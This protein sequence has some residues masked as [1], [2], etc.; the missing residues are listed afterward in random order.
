[1][2]HHIGEIITG[3]REEIH[4]TQSQLS[5]KLCSVTELTRIESNQRVPNQ[6]LL[7]ML[8][9]RLGKATDRLEYILP[10]AVYQLYELR[11]RIQREI[12]YRRLEAAE[13]L[14]EEYEKKKAAYQPLHTQFIE[15]ERAQIA[16]IRKKEAGSVLAHLQKAIAQTMEEE[17]VLNRET[18]LSADE[19]RLLLFRWEVC[20]GTEEER[21]VRELGRILEYMEQRIFETEELVRVYPYAVILCERQGIFTKKEIREAAEKALE[22]L[23][24]S[25]QILFLVEILEILIRYSESEQEEKEYQEFRRSVVEVQKEYGVHYEEFPL[26]RCFNR[27]FELD[28]DVIRRT[29]SALHLSQEALCEDICTQETLSRIERGKNVP[30]NETLNKLMKKMDRNRQRIEMNIVTERYEAIQIE[31][32]LAKLESRKESSKYKEVFAKLKV[33]IDM[34][35]LENQQYYE[36]MVLVIDKQKYSY[37]EMIQKLYDI[38]RITL[39]VPLNEIY[40]YPLTYQEVLI[41]NLIAVYYCWEGKIDKGIE[42]WYKILENLK[43]TKIDK[44]FLSREWELILG[45]IA[46]RIAESGEEWR[47]IELSKERLQMQL[48]MGKGVHIGRTIEIITI[49]MDRSKDEQYIEYFRRAMY[50]FKLM[51]HTL[52]Y[53]HMK[54]YAET[55]SLQIR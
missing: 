49:A 3:L 36:W 55:N 13:E 11:F 42:I 26:F 37:D 30:S 33:V 19:I 27:L 40:N 21:S 7:D 47:A 38:L 8:F 51:K 16:W 31:R 44:V 24:D 32:E 28:S 9:E 39:K 5:K 15:Q 48:E 1:M 29:R 14:L 18:L 25:G 17:P 46:Q 45:N 12:L 53:S 54:Q 6:F 23:R 43:L 52:R 4:C 2:G 50:W 34:T 41:L 22:L 20:L 10:N 35:L